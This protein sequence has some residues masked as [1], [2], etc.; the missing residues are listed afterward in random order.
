MGDGTTEGWIPVQVPGRDG[1]SMEKSTKL[2]DGSTHFVLR[3][4]YLDGSQE[5]KT[6]IST[7]TGTPESGLT[8]VDDTTR[9]RPHCCMASPVRHDSRGRSRCPAVESGASQRF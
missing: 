1:T 2:P 6:T 5:T 4:D 8:T 7:E 9:D 3:T